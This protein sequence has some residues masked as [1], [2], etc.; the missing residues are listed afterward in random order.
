MTDLIKEIKKDFFLYRNGVI[1]GSLRNQY[2][3]GKMIFGLMIPQI[4]EL[5]TKY[6]KSIDIAKSLWEDNSSREIR[7]LALYLFPIHELSRGSVSK[8]IEDLE[9][10]EQAEFLAFKILRHL[11]F[12]KELSTDYETSQS[13]SDFSR[14]CLKMLNKNLEVLNKINDSL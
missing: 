2:P 10:I 5:S 4:Q 9:S 12:A 7:L 8:M 6:P 14:H 3:S 1:A 13:L 11:P